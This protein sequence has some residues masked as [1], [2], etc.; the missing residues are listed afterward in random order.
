MLPGITGLVRLALAVGA[1][2]AT[3][4]PAPGAAAPAR[5][6]AQMDDVHVVLMWKANVEFGGLWIAQEKGWFA[7]QCIN[8]TY[9]EWGPGV[10]PVQLVAAG[11]AQFGFQDGAGVIVGR[12]NARAPIKAVLAETQDPPFA[13]MT[14]ADGPKTVEELK[15]KTI[16]YQAH[17]LYLVEAMLA[18]AGLT[19]ADVQLVPV[20]FDPSPL[21]N[22]QVDAFLAYVTNEPIALKLEK[23]IETNVIRAADY[24]YRFY[25]DVLFTTDD[26]IARN[27]ELVRRFVTTARRGW[28]YALQNPDET[29][30]LVVQKYCPSCS[31]E[32][33]K[34]EMRAF[35]PLATGKD[36]SFEVVGTMTEEQWQAGIDL[37]LK[38]KQIDEAPAAADLFTTE[39]L[40]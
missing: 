34:A 5:Q 18:Y 24:G 1:A 23:G 21:L 38:Y 20:E 25:G 17:E 35:I 36:G 40:Q 19:V 3:A 37:L 2:L 29:A 30:E 39:F 31:L 27:P 6:C 13:L 14:L 8:L 33:Q 26:L 11:K 4:L 7:E 22:G 32:H 10:D 15:G 28:I 9:T 12:A 16:G